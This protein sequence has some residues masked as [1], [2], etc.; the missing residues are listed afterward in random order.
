M[1]NFSHGDQHIIIN[2]KATP[3]ATDS[4]VADLKDVDVAYI[5]NLVNFHSV[6]FAGKASGKAVVKSIFQTPEAY[7]NL[8][9]KDFVFE[10]GPLGTLHAK[11]AYDNQE[12][13]INIDATA[14][15]G[16][17]HLTVING[18]VSPKRN[19]ID[20]GIEA[21]N[22]SLKFMEN[23]CGSFLN[24]VEA[25]CKGKLN[26]VGDLKTSTSWAT[27]WHTAECT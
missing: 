14:E 9:V 3:Q 2:G 4:I 10:N 12:G 23:F 21:H 26:V 11:A 17:E 19:Y 24:N 8:D 27:S 6:D 22:T 5:L 20:L 16:P 7:A 15:D 25:W 18:Y 1:L 13:Q